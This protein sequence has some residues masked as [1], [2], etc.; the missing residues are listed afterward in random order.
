MVGRFKKEK[1]KSDEMSKG[2]QKDIAFKQTQIVC[3]QTQNA[4]KL[5]HTEIEIDR[6]GYGLYGKHTVQ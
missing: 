1:D 5:D 4:L 6:I 3:K 2:N